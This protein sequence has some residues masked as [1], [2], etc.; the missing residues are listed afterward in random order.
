MKSP[1]RPPCCQLQPMQISR[2]CSLSLQNQEQLFSQFQDASC[3]PGR[4]L[5][6]GSGCWARDTISQPLLLPFEDEQ[7]GFVWL[8]H[9]LLNRTLPASTFPFSP[10]FWEL[11]RGS[12]FDSASAMLW[13]SIHILCCCSATQSCLLLCDPMDRSTPGFLSFTISRR[14]LKLMSI[15]SVMPSN[16]LVPCHHL[17]LLP[18]IFPRIMVF[19]NEL[20]LHHQV[21]KV[22]EPQPQH[23]SFHW[24]F[25]VDFL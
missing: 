14:L 22:L 3:P 7:E 8:A 24:I 11:A 17:L 16:H 10:H 19:S 4:E 13:G 21:A 15:E 23:Q 1:G 6:L 12:G 25:R 20:A 2:H 18:S 5:L 9:H